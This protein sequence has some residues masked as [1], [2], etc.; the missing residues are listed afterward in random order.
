MDDLGVPIFETPLS[1]SYG[2]CLSQQFYHVPSYSSLFFRVRFPIFWNP[3][4]FAFFF[5]LPPI[6]WISESS[7]TTLT[8]PALLL[9]NRVSPLVSRATATSQ[10]DILNVSSPHLNGPNHME[11]LLATFGPKILKAY[12]HQKKANP[13]RMRCTLCFRPLSVGIFPTKA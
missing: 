13:S 6:Y 11:H 5:L 9:V 10:Y 1:Q 4:V 3:D 2:D 7:Q 12:N 8:P